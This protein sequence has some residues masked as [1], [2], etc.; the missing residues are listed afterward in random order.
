MDAADIL[1]TGAHHRKERLHSVQAVISEIR[2]C[3]LGMV[4]RIAIGSLDTA[5]FAGAYLD[6]LRSK[7]QGG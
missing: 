3:L 5:V 1:A 7:A 2:V 6:I 4:R